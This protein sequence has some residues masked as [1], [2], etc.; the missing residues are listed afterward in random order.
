MSYRNVY[1]RIKSRYHFD[2]GWLCE[3]DKLAFKSETRL[4]FQ[5]GGWSV[6]EGNSSGCGD[7]V[8]MGMQDLYLHPMNFDGVV[9]EESIAAISA[10]L[11]KAQTFSCYA[12]DLY[13]E[14]LDLSDDAYWALLESKREEI[15][16][17]IL[18]RYRTKRKNLFVT[19]PVVMSIA[20]QFSVHRICDKN[21][22]HDKAHLFVSELI[23]Q[24][25]AQGKLITADTRSGRGIRTAKAA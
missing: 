1:F 5:Q 9:K 14:Y 23:D 8:T 24:L 12:V 6:E 16:S 3:S 4:L 11:A 18:E 10:L 7:T 21:G 17:V 22:H 20:N 15:T 19:G 25:I 13:E 2:C